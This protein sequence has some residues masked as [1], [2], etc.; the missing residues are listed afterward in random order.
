[1]IRDL[2]KTL[3]AMLDDDPTLPD[4][5]QSALVVFDRPVE[6]FSPAQATIDLFL[7]DVR[8]NMEL[9]SNEPIIERNNGQATIHRP[10]LRVLCSYLVTAWP[11]AA[12]GDEMALREHRLLSQALQVLARYPTIPANLLKNTSL[13]AQEPPLPMITAQTDGLKNPSEFWT[14]LGNKLRPSISLS[15]TISMQPFAAETARMVQESEIRIGERTSPAEMKINP[16]SLL[17]V[18]RI[19]GQV[20]GAAGTPVAGALVSIVETGLAAISDHDGRYT[21]GMLPA[22]SYTIRVESGQITQTANIII[23][24]PAGKNFNVKLTG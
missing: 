14:A 20:T 21:I 13:E 15:V 23:P 22:G 4:P 16:A 17:D 9:R 8:E 7:Y 24:A 3:K 5:L 1:M 11:G 18:F 10:P 12:T 19:V 2:S 6:G